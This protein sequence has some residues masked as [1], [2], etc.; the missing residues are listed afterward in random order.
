MAALLAISFVAFALVGRVGIA[1]FT[2]G[3][4][5][6]RLA[7]FRSDPIA[8][9]AG[10]AFSLSFALSLIIVALD[11]TGVWLIEPIELA[12]L[13]EFACAFGLLGVA[14]V[15]TAQVQM[16]D[17]WR[18]GVDPSETT[19]LVTNGLYGRSRNPIYFGLGMYWAGLSVLL[20]HPV[21]WIPAALCWASIEII[22]RK[23]EEPYLLKLH[24]SQFQAY[25]ERSNRYLIW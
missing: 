8:A 14:L 24:G 7:D 15:V 25:L 20:P 21:I 16:G 23:V 5:G 22:V 3:N 17:A 13:N 4:H 12:Y 10:A 11:V 6:I 9:I 18:I 19:T 2:T 1:Y